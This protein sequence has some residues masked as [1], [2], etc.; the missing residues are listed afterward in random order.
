MKKVILSLLAFT[1]ISATAFSQAIAPNAGFENWSSQ[2]GEDQEPTG[3]ISYNVFTAAIFDPGNT[4]PTSVTQAGSPNNYQGTYSAKITT[5][6]L[7]TNPNSMTV[8]NRAGM[9]MTGYANFTAPYLHPGFGSQQRPQTFSYYTKYTPSG[10]DTMWCFVQLSHWNGSSRDTIAEGIDWSATAIPSYAQRTV[11]LV[12]NPA[13]MNNFPD[14]I[15]ILFSASSTYAPQA[16]SVMYV[17]ALTFSGYVGVNE[18]SENNM[19]DVYPNPTSTTTTFDV[20]SDN[21]SNVIVYDMTGR[22]VNRVSILNKKAVLDSYKMSSGIYSYSIINKDGEVLSR[23]KF[24]VS[25]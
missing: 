4:N 3:Y 13:Q 21:A 23:G 22:E 5:I 1:S 16:G 15:T 2:I 9:L 10:A 18:Q 12:Y 17:D 11:S 25:E 14:T 19:V 7:V 20:S 24:T 6:D 8:P